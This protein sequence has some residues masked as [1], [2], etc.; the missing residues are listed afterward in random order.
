MAPSTEA[1]AELGPIGMYHSFFNSLPSVYP[2]LSEASME[3]IMRRRPIEI[4]VLAFREPDVRVALNVL[5]QYQPR[6][7]RSAKLS[8]GTYSVYA[9][10]IVLERFAVN[11]GKIVGS[12][13]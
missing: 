6:L 4:L 5:R 12:R 3:L 7:A 2:S 9:T 8:S 11:I 10:L 13:R 1:L